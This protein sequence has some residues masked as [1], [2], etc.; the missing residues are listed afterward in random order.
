MIAKS[1]PKRTLTL[2]RICGQNEWLGLMVGIRV[3]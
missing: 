1:K 3:P 2:A